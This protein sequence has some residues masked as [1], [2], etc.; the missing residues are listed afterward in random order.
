MA[1]T[2]TLS[3]KNDDDSVDNNKELFAL[4]ISN[5][6][7]GL[8]QGFPVGGSLSRSAINNE[9]GAKSPLSNLFSGIMVVIVLL[10]FKQFFSNLPETVLAAI[11]IVAVSKLFKLKELKRYYKISKKEFIYAVLTLTRVIFFGI[12]QKIFIGVVISVLGILYNVHSP[13]IVELGPV[14]GTKLYKISNSMNLKKL[15]L[16]F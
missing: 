16:I 6:F 7:P 5:I 3:L 1:A 12:L 2:K 4:G 8:L 15:L 10:F 14:K 9:S 11:I 13:K